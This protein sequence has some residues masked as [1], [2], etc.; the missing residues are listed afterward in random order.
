MRWE[1]AFV[2]GEQNM[3]H[4][5]GNL[6]YHHFK[7]GLFNRPG[8]V[9][10]HFFGTATLSFADNI[11]VQAGETFEVESPQFGPALRNKL[12]VH[13]TQFAKVKTL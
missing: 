1:K 12:A 7:Y 4:T 13:A 8:D 10:I 3:S 6:E 5:I 2:S 11:S 9:H